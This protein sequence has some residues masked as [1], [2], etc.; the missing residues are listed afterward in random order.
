MYTDV[1]LLQQSGEDFVIENTQSR[2]PQHST[3]QL[4]GLELTGVKSVR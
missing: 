4:T 1:T 2:V 3:N